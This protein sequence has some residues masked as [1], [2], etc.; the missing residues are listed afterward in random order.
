MY[1]IQYL[2]MVLSIIV[3]VLLFFYGYL[4]AIRIANSE[5]GKVKG[6]TLIFCV[7]MGFVFVYFSNSLCPI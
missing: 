6:E 3:S 5:E 4:E 7:L 1:T 2:A